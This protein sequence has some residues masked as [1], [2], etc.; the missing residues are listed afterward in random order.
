[1]KITEITEGQ[2]SNKNTLSSAE[3]QKA[4]KLK[5]FDKS[6]YTWDSNQ[7]LYIKEEVEQVDEGE[8]GQWVSAKGKDALGSVG[9]SLER[10]ANAIGAKM[11]S[12]KA[13]GAQKIDQAVMG[14]F[15]N[16]NRYLGQANLQMDYSSLKNYLNALGIKN[17]EMKENFAPG[18]D[19]MKGSKGVSTNLTKNQVMA[20]IRKNLEAGVRSGTLPKEVQ[21]FIST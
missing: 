10:G 12:G 18:V 9:R 14:V 4:K 21:K 2:Y 16:Y 11:G 13:Q 17:P 8:F 19:P 5:G 15:K 7:Q 3:Y 6:K 20:I 1:M